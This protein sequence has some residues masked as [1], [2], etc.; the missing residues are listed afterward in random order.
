[1][2]QLSEEL[3]YLAQGY[4]DMQPE[5]GNPSISGQPAL[6]PEPQPLH[7]R[8]IHVKINISVPETVQIGSHTSCT[9][10]F[11]TEGP[12]GC[13][14][15]PH[16]ITLHSTHSTLHCTHYP[17]LCFPTSIHLHLTPSLVYFVSMSGI[18][19]YLS[20]HLFNF[21]A[22]AVVISRSWCSFVQVC[23]SWIKRPPLIILPASPAL[24]PTV[25]CS[26]MTS[27]WGTDAKTHWRFVRWMT[28]TR[29]AAATDI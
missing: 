25:F 26:S 27:I 29:I 16:L 14:L 18:V 23:S 2:E 17:H 19:Q 4:F 12:Q 15:C 24:G 1:M 5:L 10:A 22:P 28:F 3:Q 6:P 8:K 20:H 13:I 9:S 21:P 11:I 7:I